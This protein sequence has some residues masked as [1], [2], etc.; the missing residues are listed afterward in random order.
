MCSIEV[1]F[2]WLVLNHFG[3]FVRDVAEQKLAASFLTAVLVLVRSHVFITQ[4]SLLVVYQV[5][6]RRHQF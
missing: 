2:D 3:P 4:Q 5:F 6:I 1:G